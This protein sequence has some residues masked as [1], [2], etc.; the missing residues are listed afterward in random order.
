MESLILRSK[1]KSDLKLIADLARKIGVKVDY[2]DDEAED[3]VMINA[4]ENGRTGEYID[5][6]IF[7]QHLRK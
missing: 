5:T 2:I 6:D 7:L 1:S 4:I 3:K